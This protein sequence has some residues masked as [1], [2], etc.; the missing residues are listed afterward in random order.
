MTIGATTGF[1][2]LISAVLHPDF[3]KALIAQHYTHL[4][5]QYGVDGKE[6][7]TLASQRLAN[8]AS[9]LQWTGFPV[10]P[11]GL[12]QYMELAKGSA[13]DDDLEGVVISHAGECRTTL[14]L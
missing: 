14:L 5:V 6:D 2:D 12:Q 8:F 11:N 7:F 4:I 10:D 9:K 1:R 3:A 13:S